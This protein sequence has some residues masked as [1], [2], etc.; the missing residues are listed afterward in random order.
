[1]LDANFV[2]ALVLGAFLGAACVTLLAGSM[3]RRRVDDLT[4]AHQQ[5]IALLQAQYDV[6]Q[7]ETRVLGD[8][9]RERTWRAYER[10]YRSVWAPDGGVW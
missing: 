7:R 2:T 10:L 1:M 4:T 6:L 9:P 8:A 5:S 3:A